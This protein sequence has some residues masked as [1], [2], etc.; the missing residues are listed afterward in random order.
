MQ[1]IYKLPR[2]FLKDVFTSTVVLTVG[3]SL[4]AYGK[5]CFLKANMQ[6][7][8]HKLRSLMDV[9]TFLLKIDL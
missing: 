4:M 8:Y 6:H 2:R 3:D 7:I 1:S 9:K 5:V